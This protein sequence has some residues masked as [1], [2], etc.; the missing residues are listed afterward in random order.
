MKNM[1]LFI[2]INFLKKLFGVEKTLVAMDEFKILVYSGE[3]G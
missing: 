3:T 1:V 2:F